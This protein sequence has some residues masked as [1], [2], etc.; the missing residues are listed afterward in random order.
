MC[1]QLTAVVLL[2][3]NAASQPRSLLLF[4]EVDLRQE[5]K[6]CFIISKSKPYSEACETTERIPREVHILLGPAG[7]PPP[8]RSIRTSFPWSSPIS[9][10]LLLPHASIF[11]PFLSPTITELCGN[12]WNVVETCDLPPDRQ[13]SLADNQQGLQR[14]CGSWKGRQ[15]EQ[16]KKA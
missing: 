16:R 15:E 3:R 11:P 6:H 14:K 4:F 8:S 10:I 12:T 2:V 1:V 13:N 9:Y 7:V 5:N